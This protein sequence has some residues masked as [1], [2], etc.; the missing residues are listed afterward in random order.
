MMVSNDL[1]D[2]CVIVDFRKDPFP[3]DR[4]LFHLST[5]LE[6][7]RARLLEQSG[8]KPDLPDVMDKTAQVHELLQPRFKAESFGDVLCVYRYCSRVPGRVAISGVERCN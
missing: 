7:Q 1:R 5:F 2:L 4:V 8:W 6:R 3:D